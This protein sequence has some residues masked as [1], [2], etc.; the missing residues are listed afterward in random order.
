MNKQVNAIGDACPLPVVKAKKALSEMDCGILEVLVDNEIAV[1]NLQRL[2]GASNC[3]FS[4]DKKAEKEYVVKIDKPAGAAVGD[5]EVVSCGISGKTVVAISGNVMGTGDEVLGKI[6][7]KGFIF[8][9]T[10]LDMLPDCILFYNSGAYLSTEGSESLNDLVALEKAGVEIM[11]C[12]TCLNH[13]GI[14]EK[15]KVGTVT[16]MYSIV[17][18]LAQAGRVIRP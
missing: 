14:A 15:L 7:I 9:L 11:T 5:S 16:N 18:K 2:A 3:S 1:Q 8:A 4:Y 12:G 13:Y 6:L 10:Q 17:E